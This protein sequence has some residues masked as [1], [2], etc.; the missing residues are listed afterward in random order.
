MSSE[1]NPFDPATNQL[2]NEVDSWVKQDIKFFSLLAI[3]LGTIVGS[4]FLVESKPEVGYGIFAVG[5]IE[6]VGSSIYFRKK[7][8][9]REETLE[10]WSQRIEEYKN[11]SS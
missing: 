7:S 3:G 4:F 9:G 10:F 6:L 5:A 8:S 1:N 11:H 2:I